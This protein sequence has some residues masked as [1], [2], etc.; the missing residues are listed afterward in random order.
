M[1]SSLCDAWR[2][3]APSA[4]MIL[5]RYQ[6][7]L[8]CLKQNRANRFKAYFSEQAIETAETVSRRIIKCRQSREEVEELT[9]DYD[10]FCIMAVLC[11]VSLE[12]SQWLQRTLACLRARLPADLSSA[13][14]SRSPI[15][16][17]PTQHWPTTIRSPTFAA[18]LPAESVMKNDPNVLSKNYDGHMR[19]RPLL[20]L[21]H[22]AVSGYQEA[23]RRTAQLRRPTLT[24]FFIAY[25][26]TVH[27][28][29]R[30]VS[31]FHLC[32]CCCCCC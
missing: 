20:L 31:S 32:C 23:V 21:E 4:L 12:A 8:P 1:S 19:F 25:F 29:Q 2:R 16:H 3:A 6:T 26:Q 24:E 11:S 9:G 14:H 17:A 15:L 18:L 7:H 13:E 28:G 27:S 5:Q 30:K 22:H 10:P